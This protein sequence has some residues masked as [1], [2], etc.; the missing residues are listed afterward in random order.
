MILKKAVE[1]AN[2]RKWTRIKTKAPAL[3]TRSAPPSGEGG[4][5]GK[6]MNICV[7]LRSFAD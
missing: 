7:Y 2:E 5:L 4:H 3:A 6:T 1:S